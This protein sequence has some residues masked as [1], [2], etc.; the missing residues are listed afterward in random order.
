MIPFKNRRLDVTKPVYVYRNLRGDAEHKYSVRQ[1]GLVIAHTDKLTLRNAK[2]IVNSQGQ[3][4][5][6]ATKRKNVHAFIKGRITAMK[7]DTRGYLP[8]KVFY[9]PYTDD[10]FMCYNLALGPAKI[11]GAGCT[12]I[13]QDGITVLFSNDS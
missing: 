13:N 9:N 4:K 11:V 5:V 6:R 8:A 12:I 7:I 3:Q 1:N 2:F 10:G